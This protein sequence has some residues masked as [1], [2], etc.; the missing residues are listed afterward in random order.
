MDGKMGTGWHWLSKTGRHWVVVL[1]SRQ[2]V[3]AS[4]RRPS[5]CQFVKDC[6][7]FKYVDMMWMILDDPY[8]CGK[9]SVTLG[10]VGSKKSWS[11]G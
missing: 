9:C 8:F 10:W 5:K 4:C 6:Q 1:Q 2:S 11:K 3:Q 7:W